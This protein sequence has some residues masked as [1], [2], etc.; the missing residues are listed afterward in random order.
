MEEVKKIKER[1]LTDEQLVT[2]KVFILYLKTHRW[3]HV[4]MYYDQET[5]MFSYYSDRRGNTL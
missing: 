2:L 5:E 3:V 1:E 4:V